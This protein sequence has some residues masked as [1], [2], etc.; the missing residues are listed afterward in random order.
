MPI[1][2]GDE[3]YFCDYA[4]VRALKPSLITIAVRDDPTLLK[5]IRAAHAELLG[6]LE[7]HF[8]MTIVGAVDPLLTTI[9]AILAASWALLALPGVK[10]LSELSASLRKQALAMFDDLIAG[11]RSI[12]NARLPE[13]T[14]ETD[15][16]KE[17][18]F[19]DGDELTWVAPTG[20]EEEDDDSEMH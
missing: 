5:D 7:P 15:E 17:A 3:T 8:D 19:T 14:L 1:Q 12:S 11:R 13:F 20:K 4:D 10:G 2:I 18:V 6:L 16:E 9:E